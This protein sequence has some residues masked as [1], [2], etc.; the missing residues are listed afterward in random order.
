MNLV[1]V[2]N[3]IKV[4]INNNIIIS[5]HFLDQCY[6]RNLDLYGIKEIFLK[7]KIL[8]I[9]KQG[10][11]LYKIWYYYTE[12]KD[13]NLI[14]EIVNNQKIKFITVFPCESVRRERK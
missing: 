1:E 12:S 9:V 8:G 6:E 11:N 5:Q 14:L 7:N 2:L 4:N 10:K 3:F 13:L